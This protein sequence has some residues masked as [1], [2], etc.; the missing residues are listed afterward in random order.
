MQVEKH[1][2][3]TNGNATMTIQESARLMEEIVGDSLWLH[4]EGENGRAYADGN[5][6]LCENNDEED[7]NCNYCTSCW[8]YPRCVR[9]DCPG[10]PD[11]GGMCDACVR[12]CELNDVMED[13]ESFCQNIDHDEGS[14]WVRSELQ[15]A[16]NKKE[17]K[18]DSGRRKPTFGG[19]TISPTGN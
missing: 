10:L 19:Q 16:C 2:N 13:L 15:E 14:E 9:C 3:T 7:C 6:P 5:Y 4:G 11:G 8:A 1:I 17:R 12:D 18:S